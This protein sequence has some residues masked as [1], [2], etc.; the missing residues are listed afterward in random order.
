[1]V[2]TIGTLI[3]SISNMIEVELPDILKRVIGILDFIAIPVL[4]YSTVKRFREE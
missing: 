1:M 2:I 4:V 3:L